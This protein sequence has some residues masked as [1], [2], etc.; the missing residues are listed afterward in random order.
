MSQKIIQ[1]TWGLR[2]LVSKTSYPDSAIQTYANREVGLIQI[3]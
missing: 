1:W 3:W 2:I